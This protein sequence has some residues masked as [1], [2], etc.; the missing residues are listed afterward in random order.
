[1]YNRA[2]RQTETQY[3]AFSI[4]I[5]QCVVK[6]LNSLRNDSILILDFMINSYSV[7]LLISNF[8]LSLFQSKCTNFNDQLSRKNMQCGGPDR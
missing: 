5:A 1:M 2:D 6:I 3:G 4:D 8:N 7:V